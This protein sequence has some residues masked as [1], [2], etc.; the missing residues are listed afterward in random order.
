MWNMFKGR[1]NHVEDARDVRGNVRAEIDARENCGQAAAEKALARALVD[2]LLDQLGED[3]LDAPPE[4]QI[5]VIQGGNGLIAGLGDSEVHQ[6]VPPCLKR[7]A[8]KMHQD[9]VVGRT[10][11][12]AAS[13]TFHK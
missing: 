1:S 11:V 12:N 4:E 5:R 8:G 2:L 7:V 9:V 10:E 3:L 6:V 13:E